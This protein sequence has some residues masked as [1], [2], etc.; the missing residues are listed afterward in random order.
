ML[1]ID[2]REEQLISKLGLCSDMYDKTVSVEQLDVGDIHIIDEKT[3]L[4]V[5]IIERK[6]ILD[7]IAS[8]NDARNNEQVLRLEN[9]VV[10]DYHPKIIYIVEGTKKYLM[11]KEKKALATSLLNKTVQHN[12]HIVFTKSVM[13]TAEK[14]IKID[15]SYHEKETKLDKNLPLYANVIKVK[16]NENITEDVCYI[17]MLCCIP[18]VGKKTAGKIASVCPTLSSLDYDKLKGVVSELVITKLNKFIFR[19]P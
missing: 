15:L 14:V 11:N 8:I 12:C 19:C 13:D 5:I 17:K 3:K 1:I 7:Y 6:S 16:K 10:G 4:P 2:S 9:Y 18:G